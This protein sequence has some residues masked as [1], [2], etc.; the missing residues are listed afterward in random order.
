MN[1]QYYAILFLSLLGKKTR[2]TIRLTDDFDKYLSRKG[3]ADRLAALMEKMSGH[4][5][6]ITLDRDKGK[7]YIENT[8]EYL[9]KAELSVRWSLMLIKKYFNTPTKTKPNPYYSKA[10]PMCLYSMAEIKRIEG[11]WYFKRELKI[12]TERKNKIKQRKC[13]L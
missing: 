12:V 6:K 7:F 9:T 1:K 13:N 10:A 8:D 2:K 4:P 11:K 3:C 5:C